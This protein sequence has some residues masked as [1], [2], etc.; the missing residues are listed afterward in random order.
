MVELRQTPVDKPELI[1][2][3]AT[4]QFRYEQC[5]Y[6]A[7]LMVDHHIVRF[8]VSM[9]DATRMCPVKRTQYLEDVEPDFFVFEARIEHAKVAILDVFH[10]E[11][12]D[13]RLGLAHDVKQ[14][15]DVGSAG[16]AFENAVLALDLGTLDGLEDFDDA[17]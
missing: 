17:P 10:N 6:L 2:G 3:L 12:G 11:A 7:S 4:E 15:D 5:T 1:S 9:H 8:N 14:S 16:E 13:P